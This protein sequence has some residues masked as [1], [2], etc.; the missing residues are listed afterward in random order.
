MPG[1]ERRADYRYDA[2][3]TGSVTER[4]ERL[5]SGLV[6]A[7]RCIDLEPR[8]RSSA[9]RA[10][11]A[12]SREASARGSAQIGVAVVETV[13]LFQVIVGD[14]RILLRVLCVGV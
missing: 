2:R 4:A 13:I 3:R 12:A 11:K 8:R 10:R 14:T 6:I 9:S 7:R 5:V 1:A